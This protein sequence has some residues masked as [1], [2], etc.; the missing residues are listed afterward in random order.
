[1]NT[2]W[3]RRECPR[4]NSGFF[5]K[6]WAYPQA[7]PNP[8]A[9]LIQPSTPQAQLWFNRL[10]AQF[11]ASDRDRYH[12]AWTSWLSTPAGQPWNGIPHLPNY[13]PH[14]PRPLNREDYFHQ[15]SAQSGFEIQLRDIPPHQR[16]LAQ[17]HPVMQ[18]TVPGRDYEN[19]VF[20]QPYILYPNGR[21]S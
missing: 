14:A 5:Y 1:M 21:A 2:A 11:P 7:F 6:G 16:G 9:Q 13:G 18:A 10:E 8:P 19:Y 20:R 12:R 4:G 15:L 3:V 17:Q